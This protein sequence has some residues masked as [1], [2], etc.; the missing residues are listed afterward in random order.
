[1]RL[2][3]TD[4]SVTGSPTSGRTAKLSPLDLKASESMRLKRLSRQAMHKESQRQLVVPIPRGRIPSEFLIEFLEELI[5][6]PDATAPAQ[7]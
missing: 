5:P 7:S 2:G 4:L 1:M 3:V 6:N